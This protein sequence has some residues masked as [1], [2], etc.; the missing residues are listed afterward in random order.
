MTLISDEIIAQ[1]I[2][3]ND[4]V[5]LIGTYYPLKAAGRNFK[6]N[7]PFHNEK[8][9]SFVI[10]PVKQIFHCFGCGVGG[11]VISFVMKQDRCEFPEAVRILARRV[12][13]EMP[14]NDQRPDPQANLRQQLF[15]INEKVVEYFHYKLISDKSL[16]GRAARKYLKE[17]GVSLDMV[18]HFRLGYAVDQ[19]DGVLK[20]LKSKDIAVSLIEKAGL[21]VAK[22]SGEGFYDRFRHRIMFPIFDTQGHCRAFGGRALEDGTVKYINS[23]ETFLYT[24]G[25]HL[26]GFE[27]AKKAIL[28]ED[29]VVVVEGYLDCVMPVQA[30]VQNVVASLGTALTVEQIRLLRRYTKN[31]IMLYDM[32]QAGQQAMI[33][34]LDILVEEGMNVSIAQLSEGEDPDSF[35]CQFGVDAFREKLSEAIGFFE[36]KLK[37]LMLKIDVNSVEGAAKISD[38]M[39]ATISRFKSEVVRSGYMKKLSFALSVPEYALMVELKKLDQTQTKRSERKAKASPKAVSKVFQGVEHSI[40]KLLLTEE[41]FIVS[42]K[43]EIELNDF[44]DDNVRHVMTKIYHWFDQGKKIDSS[45]LIGS[46]EDSSIQKMI[47]SLAADDSNIIGDTTKMHQ[48]CIQRMKKDRRKESRQDLLKKIKQA[49]AMGEHEKLNELKQEFL[50]LIK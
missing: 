35:I 44:Q 42:T 33:R 31:V 20:Y 13:L 19:W 39:L 22:D 29:A 48:D 28:Q 34:S 25:H 1:V 45:S 37:R 2:D 41:S 32:D 12:N 47:S 40:L 6:I 10:N 43:Q 49:E 36:F 11:N 5:D 14:E 23:P 18:K 17:R 24:K 8:S 38:E 50:K 16:E 21:I 27:S 4:I 46:F 9:P 26:Y 30:G 7:C 15:A 3:R